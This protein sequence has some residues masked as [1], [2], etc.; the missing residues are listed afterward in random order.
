MA[1]IDSGRLKNGD[2]QLVPLGP[3]W[4]KDHRTAL[5]ATIMIP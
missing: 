5:A 3:P 1:P 2:H 4:S